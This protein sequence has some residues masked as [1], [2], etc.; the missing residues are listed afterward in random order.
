GTVFGVFILGLTQTLI[1]FNG[2][3]SSWWTKVVI[4]LLTLI[5]IGVQSLLGQSKGGRRKESSLSG[6][7]L[8]DYRKKKRTLTIGAIAAVAILI[9]MAVLMPKIGNQTGVDRTAQVKKCELQPYRQHQVPALIDKGA[10]IVYE[11][12]GGPNCI[13]EL[14]AIYPDGHIT[15]NNVEKDI[16]K[17]ITIADVELLM[18]GITDQGWFTDELYDT[19]HTPCGQCY[20][21]YLTVV[22]DG[23]EKTVMGVDGGTDA[24]A[25]Y[26]QIISLVKGTV[27]KFDVSD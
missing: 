8:V 25:V 20:G 16:E 17:Q 19:W 15:G 4:G 3:L 14:Y 18:A 23:Q 2:S 6:Q 12:N 10:I 1:Q 11:R 13:D 27:P 5:F 24:P 22:K 9:G 26:W 7:A 21:Y